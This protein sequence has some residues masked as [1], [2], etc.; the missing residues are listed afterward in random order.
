M[1]VSHMKRRSRASQICQYDEANGKDICLVRD[2]LDVDVRQKKNCSP[3]LWYLVSW[4]ETGSP[5]P[6]SWVSGEDMG[7]WGADSIRAFEEKFPE[8]IERANAEMKR[9]RGGR[10]PR[11]SASVSAIGTSEPSIS[12]GSRPSH[13]FS[14]A[15]SSAVAGHMIEFLRKNP[16]FAF[17][18]K[19]TWSLF[20]EWAGQK[21]FQHCSIDFLLEHAQ[22]D[23]FQS[24]LSQSKLQVALY[25]PEDPRTKSRTRWVRFL[26]LFFLT[27]FQV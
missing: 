8:K 27:P 24:A 19:E 22:S 9:R 26:R 6:D 21:R 1:S 7:A 15:V 20:Q 18:D 25:E 10:R 14:T 16:S 2:V 3:K 13:R 11:P 5:S 17:D 4:Q 23:A 12:R